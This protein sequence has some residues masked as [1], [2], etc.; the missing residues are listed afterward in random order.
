MSPRV[1]NLI[2][3][4]IGQA[5]IVDHTWK[6]IKPH[7]QTLITGFV[8]PHMCF[9]D[10]DQELWTEDPQ[11]YIRKARSPPTILAFQALSTVSHSISS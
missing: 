8:F 2:L 10:E 7:V 9:S 5:I 3:K 4:Y 1:V 11:E 6:V